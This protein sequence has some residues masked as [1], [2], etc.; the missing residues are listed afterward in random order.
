MNHLEL[1]K[2]YMRCVR[3]FDSLIGMEQAGKTAYTT[4]MTPEEKEELIRLQKEVDDE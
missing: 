2:K 3:D 4:L 1:L